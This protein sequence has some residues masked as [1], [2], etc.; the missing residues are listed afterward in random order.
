MI[1]V[2]LATS[3]P[4]LALTTTVPTLPRLVPTF[5]FRVAEP[6]A[7]TPIVTEPW[8]VAFRRLSIESLIRPEPAASPALTSRIRKEALAPALTLFRDGVNRSPERLAR[9]PRVE[10]IQDRPAATRAKTAGLV[11]AMQSGSPLPKL[12]TP[13]RTFSPPANAINGPPLSP[14]QTAGVPAP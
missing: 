8:T 11:L 12:V 4:S 14:E 2:A 9:R 7:S 10:S 3:P 5:T 6:P 13:A 1:R